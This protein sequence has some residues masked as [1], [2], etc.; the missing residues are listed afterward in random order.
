MFRLL[1]PNPFGPMSTLLKFFMGTTMLLGGSSDPVFSEKAAVF[2][3]QQA[4]VSDWGVDSPDLNFSR[5][6]QQTV[7]AASGVAW[8]VSECGERPDLYL[9][10]GRETPA[11]VE[12]NALLPDGTKV[13]VMIQV[14]TFQRG[15]FGAPRFAHAAI[16]QG[17][18]LYPV[19]CLQ[20]LT[21]GLGNP[22][23][24]KQKYV[25]RPIVFES[26]AAARS[27]NVLEPAAIASISPPHPP[28]ESSPRI[29]EFPEHFL[30]GSAIMKATALFPASARKA[31][32]GGEVRIQVIVSEEGVVLDAVAL[33]GPS[34]L[35]R[36]A[37]DAA[38]KWVFEPPMVHGIRVQAQSVLTFSFSP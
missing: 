37:I 3:A 6:F 38:Y 4:L 10:Q 25:L 27:Q 21:E 15:V 9:A 11:C 26:V 20:D 13:M 28:D 34:L 24:L 7:G 2:A 35:R 12:A 23:E 1:L 29:V 30:L 5:W 19:R 36:S 14:G 16:E 22:G 8:Q 32:M 31:G 18:D 33:S 17:G